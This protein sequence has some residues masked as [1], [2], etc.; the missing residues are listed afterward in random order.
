MAAAADVVEVGIPFTDPMADGL[1]IQDAG[2]VALEQG[3]TL[4]S[5]LDIL[6]DLEGELHA[7]HVLMGYYNPF[8][9]FGLERLASE[10][11][12][13][14]TSGLIV[15]DLPLEESGPLTEV[16]GP[17]G[18]ALVQLVTPTTPEHRLSRLVSAS[19]GFVYAVTMTGVTGGRSE[20]GP[21]T[22]EYL[23]RVREASSLP[24]LAGFGVRE[25]GQVEMLAPHV[26]GVIVGS[27]LIETIDRGDDPGEFLLGLRPSAVSP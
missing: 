27:A 25:R 9:A 6:G 16:L 11:M 1:T 18:R 7:P 24:V 13:V 19:Q 2:R 22:L 5:I 12:R 23:H 3:V 20:L 10:M 8:L 4:G 17:M 26:D 15:P 14:G 21:G